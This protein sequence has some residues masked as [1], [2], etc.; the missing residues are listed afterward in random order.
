[1]ASADP[2]ATAGPEGEEPSPTNGGAAPTEG[3]EP[4]LTD[5]GAA[6]WLIALLLLLL[7]AYLFERQRESRRN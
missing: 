6:L 1:L 4:S 7:S 5:G 2:E 3:E